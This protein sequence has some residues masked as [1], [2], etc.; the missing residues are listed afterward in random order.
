VI[1]DGLPVPNQYLGLQW[2]GM[3]VTNSQRFTACDS[4]NGFRNGNVSD[5]WPGGVVVGWHS[6]DNTLVQWVL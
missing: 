4:Y 6:L 1:S 3:R 5:C 2:T